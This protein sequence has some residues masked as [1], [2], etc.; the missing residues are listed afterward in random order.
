MAAMSVLGSLNMI[1]GSEEDL[2]KRM[3]APS[4]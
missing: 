4:A 3:T 2:C 1:S